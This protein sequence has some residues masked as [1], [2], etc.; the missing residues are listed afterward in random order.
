MLTLIVDSYG[1]KHKKSVSNY[2]VLVAR[3]SD[4]RLIQEKDARADYDL[5][6]VD[7]VVLSGSEKCLTKGQY[8]VDYLEFIRRVSVPLLGV[9]YGHQALAKAYGQEVRRSADFIRKRFPK[10]PE[11]VRIVR[12]RSLFESMKSPILAD[13]SHREEVLL[14]NKRFELL[15]SSSS[16][17]VEAIRL[18]DSRKFGVQFHLERSGEYGVAIMENFFKMVRRKR[19][20]G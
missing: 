14:V 17:R 18:R 15:G 8:E 2:L 6:S 4:L 3:F 13:E 12:S 20:R 1:E 9:C 5:S 7:A 19:R 16:C 10:K 11:R